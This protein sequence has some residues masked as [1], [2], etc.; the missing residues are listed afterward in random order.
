MRA[1]LLAAVLLSASLAFSCPASAA[2]AAEAESNFKTH[3]TAVYAQLGLGTPLGWAGGEIEQTLTSFL[4]I[5]GGV[6]MGSAG[7]QVAL[8][9]RLRLGNLY[10]VVTLGAGV[11]YGKY[12]WDDGCSPDCSP[13]VRTGTVTWGNLEAGIEHRLRSGFSV[14]YFAGYGHVIAGQLTCTTGTFCDV[15]DQNDGRSLFY[16]GAAV[17]W[18]F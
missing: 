18:A 8:M 9:P 14:R 2:A 13:T 16:L 5:S 12:R 11:S 4:A 3:P 6:G 15:E 1:S 17:G 7:P 10:T